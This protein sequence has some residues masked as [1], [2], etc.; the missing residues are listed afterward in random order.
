VYADGDVR[1]GTNALKLLA[2][3]ARAVGLG[4][5]FMFA[6]VHGK[7]GVVRAIQM[8]KREIATSAVAL[9]VRYLK[10]MDYTHVS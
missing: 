2:L 1:Y 9:R 8:L 3:G 5:P 4:R 7:E 6:N 10:G